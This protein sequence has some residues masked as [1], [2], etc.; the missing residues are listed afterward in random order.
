MSDFIKLFRRQK[1]VKQEVNDNSGWTAE[2]RRDSRDSSHSDLHAHASLNQEHS[3]LHDDVS[4]QKQHDAFK[5]TKS[6]RKS[7]R[8]LRWKK[9]DHDVNSVSSENIFVFPTQSTENVPHATPKLSSKVNKRWSYSPDLCEDNVPGAKELRGRLERKL[10]VK[11]EA[12]EQQIAH[13]SNVSSTPVRKF[14]LKKEGSLASYSMFGRERDVSFST[15]SPRNSMKYH[16][17][18][19]QNCF[20][21]PLVPTTQITQSG[22]SA[23]LNSMHELSQSEPAFTNYEDVDDSS[24]KRSSSASITQCAGTVGLV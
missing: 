5:E 19:G 2:T 15:F 14:S 22:G 12:D 9:R 17:A 3:N 16:S 6:W 23:H 24:K 10:S 1:S 7:F 8:K 18:E 11:R 21:Q 13:S 4:R 20:S